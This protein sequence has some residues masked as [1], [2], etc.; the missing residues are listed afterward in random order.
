MAGSLSVTY[1]RL[2]DH[3]FWV[4]MDKTDVYFD[5]GV[6]NDGDEAA[7]ASG[8]STP[9]TTPTARKARAAATGCLSSVPA[10]PRIGT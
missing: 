3:P 2:S 6:T 8:S 1:V 7:P 9:A 10:P 4:G 5:Y